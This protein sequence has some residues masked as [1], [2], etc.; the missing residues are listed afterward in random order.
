MVESLF[1]DGKILT[2]SDCRLGPGGHHITP[3]AMRMAQAAIDLPV[4][5]EIFHLNVKMPDFFEAEDL[6][7]SPAKQCSECCSCS[8]CRFRGEKI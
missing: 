3:A 6:G 5:G 8:N 1:G 4:S 2:G 7:C